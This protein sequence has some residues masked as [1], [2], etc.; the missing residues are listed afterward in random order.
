[1]DRKHVKH[2]R[3]FERTYQWIR[4]RSAIVIVALIAQNALIN[5]KFFFPDRQKRDTKKNNR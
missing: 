4:A 2:A 1:M 5:L 3:E